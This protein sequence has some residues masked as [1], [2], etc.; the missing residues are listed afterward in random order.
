MP[1][2]I[3]T[4]L[5]IPDRIKDGY[6]PN[7]QGLEYLKNKGANLILTLDCGI[8]AFDVLDDFYV[9]GG[10]VIV[11]DHHMAEPKLPKAIAVV[12]PNRLDDLSDLW[13]SCCCRCC[14][15]FACR[16]YSKTS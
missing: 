14:F 16:T 6:G 13:E 11:V 2:N 10:E 3:R 4:E 7:K 15:S 8:L 9:Q 12:N 1:L 5:Y